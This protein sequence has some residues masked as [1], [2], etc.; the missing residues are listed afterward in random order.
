MKAF[1]SGLRILV[2]GET[3]RLPLGV[4]VAVLVAGGLRLAAGPHGWFE[5][6]GGWAL[7]GLLVGALGWA[8][9]GT[10]KPRRS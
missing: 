10:I 7:A 4:A 5:D 1:L 2:L 8:L 3:W 6:T 9:W